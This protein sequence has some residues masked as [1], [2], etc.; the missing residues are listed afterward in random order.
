[1]ERSPAATSISISGSVLTTQ[2]Q[3]SQR[4]AA[5]AARAGMF[6]LAEGGR[7]FLDEIGAARPVDSDSCAL[8]NVR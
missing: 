3:Q 4:T 7:I 5:H 2:T 6:Q 8:V 1:L